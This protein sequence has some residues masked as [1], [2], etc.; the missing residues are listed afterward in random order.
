MYRNCS[1]NAARSFR[2][3]LVLAVSTLVVGCKPDA[4]PTKGGEK[5]EPAPLRVMVIDDPSLADA[6]SKQWKSRTE[7]DIKIQ[8]ATSEDIADA[9]RIPA[10]VVVFPTPQLGLLAE[11]GLIVPLPDDVLNKEPFSSR[12]WMNQIRFAES[13]W[14]H[15]TVAVP[16]GSPQLLFVYR[17]TD[18]ERLRLEPPQTWAEY[19]AIALRHSG[20]T[21]QEVEKGGSAENGVQSVLEPLAQTQAGSLLLARAA[22]YATHRD[23]VAAL[24]HPDTMQPLID[25]PPFV[26]ALEELV[27][28][29]RPKGSDAANDL[30]A[31]EVVKR[32]AAGDALMGIGFPDA[33]TSAR[34]EGSSELT[35]EI[36][37]LPLP[38]ASE[39]Y[40]FA[41][42]QW[43]E[44]GE[45][46][47]RRATLAG[48]AGRQAAVSSSAHQPQAAVNFVG[49][50]CSAEIADR[51]SP[52]S[53]ATAPFRESQLPATGRWLGLPPS[54][55]N[56]CATAL[57]QS[58]TQKRSLLVLRIPG[59]DEYMR[60]LDEAVRMAVSQQTP[61]EEALKAAA[62]KWQEVTDRLGREEQ[63]RAYRRSLNVVDWP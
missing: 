44:T 22:A 51:I 14:G 33:V 3:G 27:A 16:M 25:E 13:R 24:F 62:K 10:D 8:N 19:Q 9:R 42:G 43:E 38:G 39:V 32:V 61:P 18:F 53:P 63:S 59:Q 35:S 6:I 17:P 26:R 48:I 56:S 55:A 45:E 12:D 54:S 1:W 36:A 50:L 34:S 20:T 5:T 15:R 58:L 40:N 37:F 47:N 60:V 28:A 7:S 23:Q 29:N 21:H 49:W 2:L 30:T 4:K 11:R 52:S 31:A 46:E 57:E 41:V